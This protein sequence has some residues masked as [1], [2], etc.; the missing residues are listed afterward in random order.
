MAGRRKTE[1]ESESR[2][3]AETPRKPRLRQDYTFFLKSE[4]GT[5]SSMG[6]VMHTPSEAKIVMAWLN[7]NKDEFSLSGDVTYG[8]TRWHE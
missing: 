7:N 1:S 3:S 6:L 5:K 8:I 2:P 4:D